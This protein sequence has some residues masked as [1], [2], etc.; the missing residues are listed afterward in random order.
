MQGESM[1]KSFELLRVEN[2]LTKDQEKLNL[3]KGE[4]EKPVVLGNARIYPGSLYRRASKLF[5]VAKVEERKNLFV[6]SREKID[7]DFKDTR[8]FSSEGINLLQVAMCAENVPILQELFPFTKPISL[9]NKRTTVGCGDRLG[10]ASAAHIQAVKQFDA[11]PV[12]AQQSIRENNFLGR[13]Y[14][15]VVTDAA[16]MVFQEGYEDGWGADGDHL[17][18]IE[19]IDSAL[20]VGMPMITLDLTEVL[21][22]EAADFDKD[23]REKAFSGLDQEVREYILSEYSGQKF[24]FGDQEIA[25]DEA[26][27]KKCALM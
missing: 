23:R 11:F 16:F 8:E 24:T 2:L 20:K 26:E 19:D 12:L 7:A 25:F 10:L 22:P 6:A 9:R 1:N 3:Y 4:H 15:D 5:F 14:S 21:H 18:T 17:K 27:A 13:T